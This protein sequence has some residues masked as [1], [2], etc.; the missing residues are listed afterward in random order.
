MRERKLILF[1]FFLVIPI[2]LFAQE[3]IKIDLSI[4][5]KKC[6]CPDY[7]IVF[8]MQDSIV[9]IKSTGG[10]FVPDTTLTNRGDI[11]IRFGKKE[12]LFTDLNLEEYYKSEKLWQLSID[13]PPLSPQSSYS[14]DSEV[15]WAYS[16]VPGNT[17]LI[18]EYRYTKAKKIKCKRK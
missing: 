9:E 8:I 2:I 5:G 3:P 13:Y 7:S 15:K 4:D 6:R 1:T 12:L 11:A 10:Y 16:L 14:S 17:A 18:T